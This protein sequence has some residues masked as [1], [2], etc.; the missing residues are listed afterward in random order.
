MHDVWRDDRHR[1][2]I[3]DEKDS[4]GCAISGFINEDGRRESGD[5]IIRSIEN[6]H[7]RGNGLGGGFAAYGIYPEFAEHY[8]LHLMYDTPDAQCVTEQFVETTFDI[9]HQESIPTAT[10]EIIRQRPLLSRYFVTLKADV[11]E[12]HYDLTDDDIVAM[13]VMHINR[14]I[15]GAFV[16]SSGRNMGCFKGVGYPEDIGRFFRLEEYDAYMWTAHGRFPTNTTGWW[17]GA[18]PFG[19][20][21]W[22][23]VHNGEVSSYGINRRYLANFGYHCT[24]H[25]DTEVIAYLFDLLIRKHGLP[26]EIACLAMAPPLWSEIERMEPD[27]RELISTLRTVY[28]GALLNGPFSVVVTFAGGMIGF[29][30][31]IKLRPMVAARKNNTLYVASEEA[32]IRVICDDPQQIWRPR[33]GEPVIGRL[34][35]E[36]AVA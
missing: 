32:A 18:H 2:W 23:V 16:F 7:D 26:I 22:A 20:L 11:R 33:G 3:R 29:N 15:D 4:S 28:G 34:K 25:T 36:V 13:N 27:Q 6:M 24:M 5:A 19:L 31:R 8:C 21:D 17:G 30:D 35:E 1:K 9:E 12:R 10:L 14:V